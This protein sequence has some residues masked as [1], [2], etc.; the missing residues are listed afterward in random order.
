MPYVKFD[1]RN[2]WFRAKPTTPG[3][4]NYDITCLLLDYVAE[5]GISYDTISACLSACEG[6]K[7]EFYRRQASV[8]E[9]VKCRENG[10]VYPAKLV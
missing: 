10:D 3:D 4:L 9:D 6:A 2:A 1:R 7:L 8:Y 5:H